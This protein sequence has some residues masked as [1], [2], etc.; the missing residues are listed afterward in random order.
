MISELSNV[1]ITASFPL[2][3]GPEAFISAQHREVPTKQFLRHKITSHTQNS[4]CLNFKTCRVIHKPV[5]TK[6]NR[7]PIPLS[8]N[9]KTC[10]I[11]LNKSEQ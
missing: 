4:K 3:K 7:P 6:T 9:P 1:Q 11:M 5:N 2:S 8:V 10:P